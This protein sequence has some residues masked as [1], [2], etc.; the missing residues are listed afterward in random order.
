MNKDY[1][2]IGEA[3]A[4]LVR[5]HEESGRGSYYNLIN[6]ILSIQAGNARIAVVEVE[7]ELPE[8]D[9]DIQRRWQDATPTSDGMIYGIKLQGENMK[10]KAGFVKEIKK[11]ENN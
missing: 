11:N 8:V 7:S 6:D 9:K 2:A 5:E 10:L 3:I 4:K 1:Q